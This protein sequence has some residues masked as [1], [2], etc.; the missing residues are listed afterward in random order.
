[1]TKLTIAAV[2]LHIPLFVKLFNNHVNKKIIFDISWLLR[3]F[4]KLQENH[5]NYYSLT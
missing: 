3:I 5:E 4:P 2:R 1:M